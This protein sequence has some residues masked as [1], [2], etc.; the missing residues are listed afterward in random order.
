[1]KYEIVYFDLDHT[2]LDFGKSEKI[3]LFNMLKH[4]SIEPE[5]KYLEIYK[6][7]TKNGGNYFPKKISQRSYCY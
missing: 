6:P 4:F 2:L 5:E 3:A 1:M 7:L